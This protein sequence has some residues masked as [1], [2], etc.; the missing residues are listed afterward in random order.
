MRNI[1]SMS[2]TV[3]YAIVR[4]YAPSFT[5]THPLSSA[6]LLPFLNETSSLTRLTTET[7]PPLRTRCQTVYQPLLLF[8][9]RPRVRIIP[10][11]Y[12][13]FGTTPPGL[14]IEIKLSCFYAERRERERERMWRTERDK[15]IRRRRDRA[16]TAVGE[17]SLA[18]LCDEPTTVFCSR[19]LRFRSLPLAPVFPLALPPNPHVL[20][21]PG[22][23]AFSLR[24]CKGLYRGSTVRH[25]LLRIQK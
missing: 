19:E 12:I 25:A 23:S 5:H 13:R 21:F 15:R 22:I 18:S 9:S 11:N 3:V 17:I 14:E 1:K 7:L 16:A 24:L 10:Y 6:P 8:S 4:L 20:I 2:T